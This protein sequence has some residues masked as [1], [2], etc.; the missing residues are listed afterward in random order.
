[1]WGLLGWD[2]SK[3]CFGKGLSRR[4]NDRLHHFKQSNI[5]CIKEPKPTH[6]RLISWRSAEDAIGFRPQLTWLIALARLLGS[7]SGMA[8]W[9]NLSP[10]PCGESRQRDKI[11]S[12]MSSGSVFTMT[13]VAMIEMMNECSEKRNLWTRIS[14]SEISCRFVLIR[15]A[16]LPDEIRA[17]H[18]ILKVVSKT[19]SYFS[20]NQL[21]D[22]QILVPRCVI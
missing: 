12:Q 22:F 10:M 18:Y 9:R 21:K 19:D 11:L 8:V 14:N 4:I 1:M 20:P 5:S 16:T 15:I 2:I 6:L 3:Q 17:D 7:T 13:F